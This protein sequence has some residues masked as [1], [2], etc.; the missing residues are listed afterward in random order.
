M[1]KAL[2]VVLLFLAYTSQGQPICIY[3]HS[4]NVPVSGSDPITAET[5][6]YL[7]IEKIISIAGLRPAFK[8]QPANIANA[9]AVLFDGERYILY[10]PVFI[11]QLTHTTGS[12]WSAVSVLAHE[13]GHHVAGHVLDSA[14]SQPLQELEADEFSG[15]IL[16]RMG[17]PLELAQS[18]MRVLAKPDNSTTHPSRWQRLHAIARG[19]FAGQE[20]VPLSC[21][22]H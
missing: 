19:W 9:A 13:I 12:Y 18:A 11:S 7:I 14:G 10:N 21:S 15:Y 20:L 4:V 6:G 5:E 2:L 16:S 8:I 3:P 17:A 22:A 1:R